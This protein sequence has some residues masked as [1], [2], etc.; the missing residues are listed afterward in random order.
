MMIAYAGGVIV[1]WKG[2]VP[3]N[4]QTVIDGLNND[5]EAMTPP[6]QCSIRSF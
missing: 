1:D 6:K 3:G 4:V 5:A 2:P